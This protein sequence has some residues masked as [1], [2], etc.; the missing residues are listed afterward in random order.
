MLTIEQAREQQASYR[1][2]ESVRKPLE[3][4]S[5]IAIVGGIA[6]GKNYLMQESKLPIVGTETTREPR[7]DDNPEL[8]TYSSLDDMLDAIEARELVQYG[9]ALPHDIYASRL[10][11]Y[12]LGQ[13]NIADIWYDA[14]QPLQNKGFKQV[15][16]VSILSRKQQWIS[17][18]A[19]RTDG[20]PVSKIDYRL[21]EARHSMRW[22]LAQHLSRAANHLI[23]INTADMVDENVDRIRAF[24]AGEHVES[25]S[26]D[27]VLAATREMNEAIDIMYSR[28]SA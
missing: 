26:D 5:L 15:R 27:E 24:S 1:G 11:D 7:A 3:G 2:K 4:T 22:S 17:Q 23:V 10:R 18:L 12:A 16:S 20:M 19:I 8:Y 6:A 25:P 14:V 9:V 13:A 28:I 21:S